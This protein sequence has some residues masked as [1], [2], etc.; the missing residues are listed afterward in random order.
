MKFTSSFTFLFLCMGIH[1]QVIF[2]QDYPQPD[3]NSVYSLSSCIDKGYILAGNSNPTNTI[4]GLEGSLMKLDSLGNYQWSFDFGGAYEDTPF[5]IIQSI[6]SGFVAVGFNEQFVG[7]SQ[8]YLI[9]KFDK[10]GA[11][12]WDKSFGST[13]SDA[14]FGIVENPVDSSFYAVGYYNNNLPSLLHLNKNGDSIWQKTF[15]ETLR[16]EDVMI[17]ADGNLLISGSKASPTEYEFVIKTDPLGNEIWRQMYL[18]SEGGRLHKAK[19]FSNGEIALIGESMHN[20]LSFG[21]SGAVR[22]ISNEGVNLELKLFPSNHSSL[23]LGACISP[24]GELVVAGDKNYFLSSGGVNTCALISKLNQDLSVVWETCF[25]TFDAVT[26]SNLKAVDICNASDGGYVICG[27]RAGMLHIIKINE[28]GSVTSINE[29]KL[30]LFEPSVYPNP[31][32]NQLNFEIPNGK[33]IS[34]LKI[35]N[36]NGQ[37]VYMSEENNTSTIT[38]Q[39]PEGMY[40]YSITIEGVLHSGKI[41]KQ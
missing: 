18:T 14:L 9:Y 6:D 31:F 26:F 34:A 28:Y 3:M 32:I 13:G 33:Q 5:Q 1:A 20:N 29:V 35:Y 19:Q 11:F 27:K 4:S 12:V 39:V 23:F 36:S 15:S 16:L 37:V 22:T 8:D 25:Y 7:Y 21:W 17:L 38:L 30:P 40:F 10:N 2:Q 24:G 41:V